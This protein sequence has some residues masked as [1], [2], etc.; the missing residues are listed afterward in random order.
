MLYCALIVIMLCVFIVFIATITTPPSD[1]TVCAGGVAVF[2]CVVDRNGTGITSDGVMWQQIRM[3]TGAITPAPRTNIAYN[4]SGNVLTSTLT[5][6][7]SS[8]LVNNS[9]RCII[10]VSDVISRNATINI[11]T[12]TVCM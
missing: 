2:T 10:P 9:Y 3:D 1:V 4:I 12:G 6:I 11:V 8:R 5:F 7:D